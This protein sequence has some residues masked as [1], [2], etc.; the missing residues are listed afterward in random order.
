MGRWREAKAKPK[1]SAS[2]SAPEGGQEMT[3]AEKKLA[4]KRLSGGTWGQ[5]TWGHILQFS[6]S[7]QLARRGQAGRR[8]RSA[9]LGN[10]RWP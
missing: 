10:P 3:T 5:G 8:W 2:V 1:R 4:R 7:S 9:R 6:T